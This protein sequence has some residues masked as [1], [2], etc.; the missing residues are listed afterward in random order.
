MIRLKIERRPEAGKFNWDKAKEHLADGL[1]ILFGMWLLF[2]LV[3]FWIGGWIIIGEP[4][5]PILTVE[6]A[7][8]LGII[9]LGIDRW[10]SHSKKGQS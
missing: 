10:R 4:S 9:A 3:L 8:A 6:T 7:I 5:K 1:V 2:H